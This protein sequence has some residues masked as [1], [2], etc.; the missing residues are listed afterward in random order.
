[1]PPSWVP[2]AIRYQRL[3][4]ALSATIEAERFHA[5]HAVIPVHSFSPLNQWIEDFQTFAA[6]FGL[7]AA[8]GPLASP[9]ARRGLPPH[10]GRVHG[11]ERF[12]N[13]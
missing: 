6:L 9:R 5:S 11:D 1:L 3:H 13:A 12:L 7:N 8:I 4:R 2:D 10:L